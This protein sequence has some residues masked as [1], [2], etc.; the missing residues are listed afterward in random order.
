MDLISSGMMEDHFENTTLHWNYRGFVE[1]PPELIK[2]GRH[3]CELYL[4]F[5]SIERLVN[6][7]LA[8]QNRISS[9]I[10]FLFPA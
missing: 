6:L 5:N 10:S 8:K 2:Y 9:K 3:I 4:K 1:L 7:I